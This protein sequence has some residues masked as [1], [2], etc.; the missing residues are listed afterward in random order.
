MKRAPTLVPFASQSQA[1]GVPLFHVAT[2]DAQQLREE[3]AV[4]VFRAREL[5]AALA[6]ASIKDAGEDAL[7]AFAAVLAQLLGEAE[8]LL[9]IA[10]S[11]RL[12]GGA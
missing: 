12:K 1:A 9:E 6:G 5:S 4:R 8:S 2:D 10:E 7:P 11:V 3:A